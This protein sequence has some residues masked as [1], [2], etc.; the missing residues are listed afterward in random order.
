MA[1]ARERAL[2]RQRPQNP[3]GPNESEAFR[4]ILGRE[5]FY[6]QQVHRFL[7]ACSQG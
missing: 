3:A 5:A 6:S 2:P 4:R 7:L 1:P